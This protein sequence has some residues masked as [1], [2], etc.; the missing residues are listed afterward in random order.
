MES[1]VPVEFIEKRIFLIRGQK[2]MLDTDL[3]ELYGVSTKRLNEQ[4][5][6]NL[7]R[8]PLDFMFQLNEE[9]TETLR[10]QFATSKTG[11]GGRRY[12][13]FVFTEQGVTML[14]TVLN[15]DR[16]IEVNIAI[17]RVFV[18]LRELIADR[19]ELAAK[20]KK[21]EDRIEDH[22]EKI[23]VVFEAIRQLM[24]PPVKPKRNI[25]FDLKEK[26]ARYGRTKK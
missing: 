3:A 4:V 7:N 24:T 22:D 26:Q 5:R 12:F 8:F 2:V 20:L 16:A 17:M 11:R 15:S 21:L 9:E 13:P 18:R 19:K 1:L 14:S 23:T 6:R 10:S 25:G